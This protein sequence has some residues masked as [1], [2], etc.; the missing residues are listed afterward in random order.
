MS[1]VEETLNEALVR[2]SD[3][4]VNELFEDKAVASGDLAR[5]IKENNRVDN[6]QEGYIAVL[7]ML[8]YGEVIDQGIGRH[9]GGAPP[10]RPIEEWL[11][12]KRIPIPTSFKS[13][14][15]FAFAIAKKVAKEGTKPKANHFIRDGLRVFEQTFEQEL[16]EA[17]GIDITEN[18]TAAFNKSAQF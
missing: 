11:K 2:L 15:S 1:K 4:F 6:T 7:T 8:W 5:S 12:R 3:I 17:A 9:A 16:T 10:V 13:P 18:L 14:K